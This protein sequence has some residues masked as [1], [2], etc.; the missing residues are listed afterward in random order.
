[1]K[2]LLTIVH[3]FRTCRSWHWSSPRWTGAPRQ[4][5][6]RRIVYEQGSTCRRCNFGVLATHLKFDDGYVP[7]SL[8]T[9]AVGVNLRESPR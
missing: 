6:C 7:Y 4:T 5:T 3:S 2:N 8:Q 1:M 9:L